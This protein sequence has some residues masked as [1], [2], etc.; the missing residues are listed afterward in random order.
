MKFILK[1]LFILLNCTFSLAQINSGTISYKL[2]LPDLNK[3]TNNIEGEKELISSA[4]SIFEEASKIDFELIFSEKKS[5]FKSNQV[6]KDDKSF[7]QRMSYIMY[8][9]YS[10]FYDLNTNFIYKKDKQESNITIQIDNSDLKWTI[11]DSVK[12]IGDYKC[13]KATTIKEFENMN[14]HQKAEVIAWFC[15][16]LPYQFGPLEFNGLPGLILELQKGKQFYIAQK[17]KLSSDKFIIE[18]PSKNIITEEEY[19]KK[20]K[21]NSPF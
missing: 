18:I 13:Y 4:K 14:G 10:Y 12:K 6:L 17:I 3:D 9:K 20:I 1:F 5:V 19:I 16:E 11:T 2:I 21:E 7:G 8:S 15:P